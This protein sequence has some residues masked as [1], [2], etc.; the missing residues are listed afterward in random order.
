MNWERDENFGASTE[1][2]EALKIVYFACFH[3]VMNC[4]LTFWW[5]SSHSAKIW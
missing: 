4:E 3:S 5:N 1:L 2:Q